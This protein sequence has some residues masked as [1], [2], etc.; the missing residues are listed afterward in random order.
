MFFCPVSPKKR[1]L[2]LATVAGFA[3]LLVASQTHAQDAHGHDDD[4]H[5]DEATEVEDIIVQAT[6]SNRRIQ[7][8]PI[9]VEVV[10]REEIMEKLLMTPGSIAML[11]NETG[12][13]RVQTTSPALGGSNIRMQG[14]NGRYTQLLA[15]GLP[16]YGGQASSLGVLQI[17]PTDLGQVEIIK[18]AASALYGPSALGGVINLVSRRPTDELEAEVLANITSRNGQD[19][20]A[21]LSAPM[22]GAWGQSIVGGYHRQT[23]Q[24]VEGDGWSDIPGHERWTLRPRLFWQG[25]NGADAFLTL[26]AMTEQREGG[27]HKSKTAPDGL[28]F[29]QSQDTDRFDAGAVATLPM[30][31]GTLHLRAST[32]TQS[33]DHRFGSDSESDR[34]N[35]GFA[36]LAYGREQGATH[37]LVGAAVQVDDYANK[38]Y[39]GFDYTYSVPGVFAQVEHEI[40]EVL[41][42]AGSARIDHHS[43]YGTQD[44]PRVSLLYRPG[45]WTIRASAGQGFF[46]PTPFVDVTEAVGLS[47]LAPLDGLKEET[48][49]T[50]SLDIGWKHGPVEAN[51]TLFGSNLD[52]AVRAIADKGAIHLV[53]IDGTTRTRG[54]EALLRYRRA[55]FVVTG[56]YVYV[57]ATE[58]DDAGQ[59]RQDTPLTPRHTAGFVAMWEDHDRGRLGLEVYYTGKQALE[60]NPYRSESPSYLEVGLLGEIVF[61]RFSLFLNAENLLNE[62]VSKH[63]PMLLPSRG[64]YGQ[65]T[66]DA[67][68]PLDGF[69]LNGGI[70]IRFGGG[71]H[72]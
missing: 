36:E 27:T 70:R 4:D 50:A 56:S 29:K 19:L 53:N 46:A 12:G 30:G 16:L 23:A 11:V 34:H 33:H 14:M 37:W 63:Q 26:G 24:D 3:S 44:S 25:D 40:S 55:P 64:E 49:R 13:V 31:E 15:D 51:L 21:Y 35:T 18:G 58:P 10:N 57:D 65:W 6:R 52:D 20:T 62:R 5:E 67:W 69:T 17:A 54:L 1:S 42:L 68:G 9:R 45:N 71:D 47:R 41:T 28:P 43:E 60:D 22:E 7:D 38:T 32:M 61:E 48:A 59:F 66:T 2:L 72:H 39:D 8:E